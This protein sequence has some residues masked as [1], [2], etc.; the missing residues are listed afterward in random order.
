MRLS[1]R[2]Y[3]RIPASVVLEVMVERGCRPEQAARML[4]Q[5]EH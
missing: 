5:L 2:S 4:R 1:E 3:M